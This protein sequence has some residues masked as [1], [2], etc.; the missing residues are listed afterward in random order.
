MWKKFA[1][2]I[3]LVSVILIYYRNNGIYSEKNIYSVFGGKSSGYFE[4]YDFSKD[5]LSDGEFKVFKNGYNYTEL[6]SL[7]S[8]KEI[9]KEELNGVTTYY[10]YS[11][12]IAKTEVISGKR[13]NL[14][15][16][17]SKDQTVIGTPLIYYGY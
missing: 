17:V 8:A 1:V 5:Y 4:K 11:P 14:Q 6:L 3:A 13:V 16:A 2:V 15:V 7:Y 10:Y 9:K 12:K